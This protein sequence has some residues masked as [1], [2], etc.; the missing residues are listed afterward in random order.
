MAAPS[1]TYTA[2]STIRWRWPRTADPP[3]K[4][5]REKTAIEEGWDWDQENHDKNVLPGYVNSIGRDSVHSN[6]LESDIEALSAEEQEDVDGDGGGVDVSEESLELMWSPVSSSHPDQWPKWGDRQRHQGQSQHHS[7]QHRPQQQHSHMAGVP[8]GSTTDVQNNEPSSASA[9]VSRWSPTEVAAA[10]AGTA[11]TPVPCS[12]PAAGEG[13][14]GALGERVSAA[15]DTR[16]RRE[17]EGDAAWDFFHWSGAD[18]GGDE[19]ST[20]NEGVPQV[21]DDGAVE[22]SFYAQQ[23]DSP[24]DGRARLRHTSEGRPV[25]RQ[26]K[27]GTNDGLTRGNKK[28]TLTTTGQAGE[29]EKAEAASPQLPPMA[30]PAVPVPTCLGSDGALASKVLERPWGS[31]ALEA[32]QLTATPRSSGGAAEE[33]GDVSEVI[34]DEAQTMAMWGCA[35]GKRRKLPDKAKLEWRDIVIALNYQGHLWRL[36]RAYRQLNPDEKYPMPLAH[37]HGPTFHAI[38]QDCRRQMMQ[39]GARIIEDQSQHSGSSIGVPVGAPVVPV[40]NELRGEEHTV[41]EGSLRHMGTGRA[42]VTGSAQT[43]KAHEHSQQRP[44]GVLEPSTQTASIGP[45]NS[46]LLDV[47]ETLAESEGGV[48]WCLL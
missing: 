40:M 29:E 21:H 23:H 48:W 19:A 35:L 8:A 41:G 34:A 46:K 39:M 7:T 11:A 43:A 15:G 31:L 33:D 14:E 16:H 30:R 17:V 27:R 24:E 25:E 45:I 44:D 6:T 1:P 2:V 12:V 18:D 26:A 4:W 10:T 32:L 38:A 9:P 3:R 28:A 22:A 20:Q 42:R 5:R 36:Y 37:F 13:E 47:S